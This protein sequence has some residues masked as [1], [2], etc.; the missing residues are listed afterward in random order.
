MSKERLKI[1]C[2]T[3]SYMAPEIVSKKEYYGGPSDIWACGVLLFNL[4]FGVFPFKSVTSEKD[5]FRKILRGIFNLSLGPQDLSHE[6]KDL[7]RQMLS[8]D[9]LDRPTACMI[10]KHPWLKIHQLCFSPKPQEWRGLCWGSVQ[11]DGLEGNTTQEE[12]S[13]LK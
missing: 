3:P 10:L 5:L 6:A 1:F 8:V 12:I 11:E 4:L 13:G 2:G 9:P 7:I